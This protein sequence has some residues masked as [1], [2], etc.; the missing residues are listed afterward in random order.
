MEKRDNCKMKLKDDEIWGIIAARLCGEEISDSDEEQ[1]GKW[2]E[3]S[4]NRRVLKQLESYYNE[5]KIR[6]DINTDKACRSVFSAIKRH[7]RTMKLELIRWWGAVA[8]IVI[9]GVITATILLHNGTFRHKA[10]EM[11]QNDSVVSKPTE[12]ILQLV[13]GKQISLKE[14]DNFSL[15]NDCGTICNHNGVLSFKSSDSPKKVSVPGEKYNIL[16]APRGKKYKVILPDSTQVYLNAESRLCFP[17]V[18]GEKK[19]CVFLE[20]EAYFDV[21][22]AENWPFIVE[23]DRIDVKVTGTRFDIKAYKDDE[24]VYATLLAGAVEIVPDELCEMKVALKPSQQYSLNRKSMQQNVKEVDPSL[25]I[26]WIDKMFVFRNQRLGDIMKDLTKWYDAEFVFAD[27]T[28]ADIRISG[29]I[30]RSKNLTKV[31]NMIK[32]LDKVKIEQQNEKYVVSTN[33]K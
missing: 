8:S 25:Y 2:L 31:L 17:S 11:A 22:K 3:S 13:N 23:T 16:K 33:N 29:S 15:R 14:N 1:L 12:V 4:E 9:L 18:F 20:G 19:R 30:E 28:A 27:K 5:Q 7:K 21:K 32:A 6:K 10:V 24:N 26:A